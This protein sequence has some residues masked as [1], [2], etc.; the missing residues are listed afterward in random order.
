MST[1]N[2][3]GTPNQPGGT[4]I[5]PTPTVGVLGVIDDVTKRLR[6]GFA[7][8]GDGIWLLGS[9]REELSGSIW[10]DAVHNGHLGGVP[11]R[12]DLSMYI[13]TRRCVRMPPQVRP[14]SPLVDGNRLPQ[15]KHIGYCIHSKWKANNTCKVSF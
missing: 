11:P 14:I 5:L 1:P 9:A 10:A 13:D 15:L 12:V 2:G 3:P 8:A 7:K 6:S 4:P